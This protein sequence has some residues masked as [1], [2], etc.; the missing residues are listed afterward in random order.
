M[1]ALQHHPDKNKDN[2]EEAEKLFKDVGEAYKGMYFDP[3]SNSKSIL[4]TLAKSYRNHSI[5]THPTTTTVLA[6]SELTLTLLHSY[7][8]LTPLQ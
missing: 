7:L 5:P 2:M 3:N 8:L 1:K 6:I 4:K